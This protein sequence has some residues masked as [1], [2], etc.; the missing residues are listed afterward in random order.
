MY[1]LILWIMGEEEE[2][3]WGELTQVT[4]PILHITPVLELDTNLRE[5]FTITEKAHSIVS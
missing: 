1:G 3:E 2:E 4:W 5:V